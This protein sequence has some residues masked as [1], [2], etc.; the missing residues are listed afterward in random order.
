[1]PELAEVLLAAK[2]VKIDPSNL[3]KF[4]I[5]CGQSIFYRGHFLAQFDSVV[6][7]SL[8]L[9]TLSALDKSVETALVDASPTW[10]TAFTTQF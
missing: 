8:G 10:L 6:F 4:L 3:S 9:L 2:N 7:I 1:M 5:A